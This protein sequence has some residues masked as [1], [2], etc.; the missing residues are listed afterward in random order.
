MEQPQ[1]DATFQDS[2]ADTNSKSLGCLSHAAPHTALLLR[3][4][5]GTY[6][7]EARKEECSES[8]ALSCLA[9]QRRGKNKVYLR[10]GFAFLL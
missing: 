1:K 6:Q 8:K 7:A 9:E 5:C 3:L 2:M 4:A 10:S